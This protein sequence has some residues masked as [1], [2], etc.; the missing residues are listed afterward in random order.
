MM[1][2]QVS[3]G[4]PPSAVTED[5][6]SLYTGYCFSHGSVTSVSVCSA[7]PL[8]WY[9]MVTGLVAPRT[10]MVAAPAGGPVGAP[11][12]ALEDGGVDGPSALFA[13]ADEG[14]VAES[15]LPVCPR[16]CCIRLPRGRRQS[17]PARHRLRNDLPSSEPTSAQLTCFVEPLVQATPREGV[18][19][20]CDML[21]AWPNTAA[22]T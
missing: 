21:D 8:I 3:C 19:R 20:G 2:V 13:A 18:A 7:P 9:L 11:A 4:A 14:A 6:I 5:S 1:M 10:C 16:S 15:P 17:P 12:G 22:M